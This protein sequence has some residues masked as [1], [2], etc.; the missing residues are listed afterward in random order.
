MAVS[1]LGLASVAA[2]SV[3]VFA[4]IKG[5]SIPATFQ[6]ILTGKSPKIQSVSNPITGSTGTGTAPVGTQTSSAI[7]NDA[8]S[9]NGHAYKYGGA[10]GTSGKNPWDCSSFCSWIL[11]HDFSLAIPGYPAGSYDGNSHGPVTVQYLTYG[12]GVKRAAVTAGD[13]CVWQTHMGIAISNTEMISAQDEA[14]GT[15]TSAIDGTSQ[16]LGEILFCRRVP[17]GNAS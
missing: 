2:G 7:A 17:S 1:G 6:D 4:G 10:P 12:S 5:Y 16:S 15:G 14:L 8:L 3:F 11:G 13:L 9:Y